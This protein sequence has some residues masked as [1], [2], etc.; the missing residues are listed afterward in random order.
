M[1][2]ND[3]FSPFEMFYNRKKEFCTIQNLKM[4]HFIEL[5]NFVTQMFDYSGLPDTIDTNY[6]ERY[7]NLHGS[8]VLVP[9]T[10]T[11]E[12]CASYGSRSGD[13]GFYGIGNTAVGANPVFSF[14]ENIDN[15]AWGWNNAT[16]TP[17]LIIFEVAEMLAEIER[18]ILNVTQNAR[19]TKP[20]ITRNDKVKT[21]IETFFKKQKEGETFVPMAENVLA[22]ILEKSDARDVITLDLEEKNVN[23]LQNL[24]NARDNILRWFYN[25]LGHAQQNTNKLA[26]QSKD[27]I[28]DSNSVSLVLPEQMLKERK[29]MIEKFNDISGYNASVEFSNLWKHEEKEID[30]EPDETKEGGN[31]EMD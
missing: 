22:D 18:S 13:V 19:S 27:E 30:A 16:H 12:W 3:I 28:N 2:V 10:S 17:T 20:I 7:F 23:Q 8:A 21:Q 29:I 11:G 25:Q 9:D 5:C 31:N 24:L 14:E 4:S 6:L 15:V 1:N 26:Q